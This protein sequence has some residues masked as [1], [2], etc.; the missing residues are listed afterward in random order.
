MNSGSFYDK[1]IVDDKSGDFDI[2]FEVKH[3][4][5][6]I[7]QDE[8]MKNKPFCRLRLKEDPKSQLMPGGKMPESV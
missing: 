6:E 1:T 7:H 8:S 5:F 3:A 4:A 2:V